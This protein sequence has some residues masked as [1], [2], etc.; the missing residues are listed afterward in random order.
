MRKGYTGTSRS[1]TLLEVLVVLSLMGSF[2]L[3]SGPLTVHLIYAIRGRAGTCDQLFL[4]SRIGDKVRSDLHGPPGGPVPRVLAVTSDRLLIG[5]A[6]KNIEYRINDTKIERTESQAGKS[7]ITAIWDVPFSSLTF[8]RLQ[9]KQDAV[10]IEL[11][12]RL[13]RAGERS[14][15]ARKTKLEMDFAARGS[16]PQAMI[17]NKEKK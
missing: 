6:E 5:A 17:Q 15:L 4:A 7:R 14:T 16:P 9:G 12:W 10:L 3:I 13:A 8:S 2:F 1:F 11:H